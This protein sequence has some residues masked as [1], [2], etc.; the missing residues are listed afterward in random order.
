M[1]P[2]LRDFLA[3]QQLSQYYELFL[4]AGANNADALSHLVEFNDNEL[5]DI[6]SAVCMRPFHIIIFK[7]AL[8]QLGSAPSDTAQ[9]P[10]ATAATTTTTANN[11]N[12]PPPLLPQGIIYGASDQKR[13][14]KRPLSRYEAAMNEAAVQLVAAEPDLAQRRA[15]LLQRAKMTLIENGYAYTRGKSRSKLARAVH[16]R[17]ANLN[18]QRTLNA[19][20]T[21]RQRIRTVTTTLQDT[22]VANNDIHMARGLA[23]TCQELSKEMSVLKTQQQKHR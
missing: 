3:H 5:N 7:R 17:E 9:Q 19:A 15:E 20:Q 10:D 18:A 23:N 4:N 22:I 12:N 11:N 13:P 2:C 8:K 6:L 14:R 21:A 1:L 16:K